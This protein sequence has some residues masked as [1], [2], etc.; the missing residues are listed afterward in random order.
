MQNLNDDRKSLFKLFHRVEHQKQRLKKIFI[1]IF[2]SGWVFEV[3]TKI[4]YVIQNYIN[5]LQAA[6]NNSNLKK[7]LNSE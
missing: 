4:D 1:F 2:F 5:I 3:F 7:D 6:H